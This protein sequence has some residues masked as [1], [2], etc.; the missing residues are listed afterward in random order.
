MNENL[1]LL[2]NREQE[3][4]DIAIEEE[5]SH[6]NSA[7]NMI[8]VPFLAVAYCIVSV[9]AVFMN[10][11]ILARSGRFKGFGSVEFLMFLQSIL[12]V[13]L[14][15]FCRFIK[16][17]SFPLILDKERIKRIAMV[18]VLFVLMTLSNAYSVRLLSLPM[19]ALLKNCQVVIVC[20]LES[21]FLHNRPGKATIAS[22]CVII[23]GSFCGSL[24]DLEFNLFGYIAILVAVTASALYYVSIKVAFKDNQVPEFSLVFYNNV[25]SIPFFFFSS[26]KGGAMKRAFLFTLH[27]PPIFWFLVIC[28][29][30]AGVGVNI[31]TYLFL[32]ATSPTSFSVLGIIKKI[33]Q[34]LLGYLQWNTP[35][36]A[37]NI[38]SVCIGVLGGISYSL[39]KNYEKKKRY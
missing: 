23:F 13:I 21:V 37:A 34:T 35:T 26:I 28:S 11:I 15:L 32:S 29:G 18:N 36:S 38:V 9:S 39:A 3:E 5:E 22:I 31:T 24:T 4:E 17:V 30:F 25:F 33:I 12:A 8:K 7:W 20:F 14:L 27:A 16:L 6:E 1:P 19:V 10:K 2:A